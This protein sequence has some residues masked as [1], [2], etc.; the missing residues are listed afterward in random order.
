L[1]QNEPYHSL[2]RH[3]RSTSVSGPDGFD[4]DRALGDAEVHPTV[5]GEIRADVALEAIE[6]DLIKLSRSLHHVVAVDAEVFRHELLSC[7]PVTDEYDIG[8]S[9][10][11]DIE[12]LSGADSYDF[13]LDACL[14]RKDRQQ[15]SK[16]VDCS[17]DVVEAR[18]LLPILSL[19][20][21]HRNM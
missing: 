20:I 19:A 21:Y 9:A 11:A 1:G 4:G 13:N 7:W 3:G 16:R 2:R 15:K 10:S 5:G 14:P 12:R 6:P 18:S 8:I 17:V